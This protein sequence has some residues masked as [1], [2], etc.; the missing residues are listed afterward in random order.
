MLADAI[1]AKCGVR[2]GA[3]NLVGVDPNIRRSKAAV[4]LSTRVVLEHDLC[5]KTSDQ[6][7]CNSCV[8]VPGYARPDWA[9]SGNLGDPKPA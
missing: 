6:S 3:F 7:V 8:I 5:D 2:L 4:P 1:H 9:R